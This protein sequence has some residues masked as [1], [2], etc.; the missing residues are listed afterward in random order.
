[1]GLVPCD[2]T[3]ESSDSE[4]AFYSSTV[5]MLTLSSN[6][7]GAGTVGNTQPRAKDY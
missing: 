7:I 2:H 1:M 4:A 6:K 3:R 5:N